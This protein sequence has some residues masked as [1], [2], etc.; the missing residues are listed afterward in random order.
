MC[1]PVAT[2]ASFDPAPGPPLG[3]DDRLRTAAL[4]LLRSSGYR[5]L[6]CLNCDV[7][8]GRAVLSGVVPSFYLKQLAQAL[9][10]RLGELQGVKNLLEVLPG[11]PALGAVAFCPADGGERSVP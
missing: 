1:S 2:V 4:G 10:L 6:R 5:P 11:G 8:D 7:R 3:R 9:L